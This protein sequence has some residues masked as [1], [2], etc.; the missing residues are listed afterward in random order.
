MY[1]NYIYDEEL[2]INLNLIPDFKPKCVK[3][4]IRYKN[5]YVVSFFIICLLIMFGLIIWSLFLETNQ[6]TFKQTYKTYNK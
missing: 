2:A 5:Y 3:H 1:N 6:N 4:W